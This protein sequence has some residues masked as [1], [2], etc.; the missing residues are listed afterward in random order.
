MT[1]LDYIAP[2]G[3]RS[4]SLTLDE[5]ML[6]QQLA[7]QWREA[8]PAFFTTDPRRLRDPGGWRGGNRS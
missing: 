2:P 8:N 6:N 3:P 4:R 1:R 7:R 5:I